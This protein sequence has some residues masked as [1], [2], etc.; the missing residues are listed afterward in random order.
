MI[1]SYKAA[2]L[3]TVR[4]LP[5]DTHPAAAYLS[6]LGAAFSREVGNSM[7][8]YPP[9]AR[10]DFTLSAT[11]GAVLVAFMA[12]GA[13][14]QLWAS[15]LNELA[16]VPDEIIEALYNQLHPVPLEVWDAVSRWEKANTPE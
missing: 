2:V 15:R 14:H 13:R 9:P 6:V 12:L 4:T 11:T 5:R 1:D 16:N 10:T 7:E 8:S 3:E